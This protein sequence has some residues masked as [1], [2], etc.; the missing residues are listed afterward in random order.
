MLPGGLA[1]MLAGGGAVFSEHLGMPGVL[2]TLLV[3]MTTVF[4][5]SRGLYGVISANAFL[6][7]LKVAVIV[8]V[9]VLALAL[10]GRPPAGGETAVN[11]GG[12]RVNWAWSAIL[13][14]SYNMVV[15]VAVLSSLGRSVSLKSG[16]TGGVAGGLVLGLAAG[17]ITSSGLAFY[18]QITSYEIPLLFIAASQNPALKTFFG[19]LIWLAILTTAIA[20]THGFASRL[21]GGYGNRYRSA[22]I[23]TVLLVLPFSTLKFS[24]LVSVLYPVFGYAGLLLLFSL[25]FIPPA[26][27]L[28]RKFNKAV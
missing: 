1:V 15:P 22:G 8:F 14:V 12:L 23:C 24:L 7:P 13:Y 25:L 26:R 21:A 4:V 9:C 10:S 11:G 5:I 27:F 19:M 3:A 17:L 2:G 6:V 16:V 28:R 20:D 18:P